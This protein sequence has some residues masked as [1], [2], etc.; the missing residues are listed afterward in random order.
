MMWVLSPR[1]GLLQMRTKET[2]Y[3]YWGFLGYWKDNLKLV[4]LQVVLLSGTKKLFTVEE[5]IILRNLHSDW[6]LGWFFGTTAFARESGYEVWNFMCQDL[7]SYQTEKN[8][9]S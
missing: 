5:T 6:D 2:A 1:H 7:S 9:Q 3:V 8:E 4:D